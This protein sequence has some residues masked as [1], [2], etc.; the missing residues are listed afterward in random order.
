MRSRLR[1]AG[2]RR[3]ADDPRCGREPAHVAPSGVR[4]LVQQD[5]MRRGLTMPRR[6]DGS[7]GSTTAIHNHVSA[8]IPHSAGH[9]AREASYGACV[10]ERV[11]FDR[12]HSGGNHRVCF[13]LRLSIGAT[14]RG[15]I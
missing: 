1:S 12:N 14:S 2:P 7:R 15:M 3:S 9:V 10:L 8:G 4:T 6:R 5:P 13:Y 11:C